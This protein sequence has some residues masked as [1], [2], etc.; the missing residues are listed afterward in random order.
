VPQSTARDE[1]L[2]SS[3][4]AN[5]PP[6]DTQSAFDDE[7]ETESIAPART[8]YTREEK[9]RLAHDVVANR[10]NHE[11]RYVAAAEAYIIS[12]RAESRGAEQ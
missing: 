4:P 7:M 10:D 6:S 2:R 1:D 12:A 3:V 5:P 9:L 11:P 8:S